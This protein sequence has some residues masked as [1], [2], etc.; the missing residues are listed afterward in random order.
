MRLF[1]ESAG[2][3]AFGCRGRCP[4]RPGR[5][6]RFY[7]NLRRIRNF[8]TGRCRHRPL[9]SNRK[10]PTNSP[11]DFLFSP[12]PAARPLRRSAPAPLRKGRWLGATET[13][14]SSSRQ[15][16][17]LCGFSANPQAPAHSIVGADAH[18]GPLGSCEFAEDFRKIGAF[19]RA[20]V[21]IGPYRH[22][23]RCLRIRRKSA[24]ICKPL[25]QNLSDSA[26]PS[27]LP[28]RAAFSPWKMKSSRVRNACRS[29][30]YA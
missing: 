19:C 24:Q 30:C 12:L 26:L 17:I 22:K 21:G 7:G 9:Q 15:L 28:F 14:R 4:H 2:T 18:I 16:Q 20:D 25:P 1:G 11:K 6:H 27:R 3:C 13:E 29:F 8:P 10:M 5:R 23:R